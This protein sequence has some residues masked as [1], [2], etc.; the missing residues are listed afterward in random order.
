MFTNYLQYLLGTTWYNEGK[1][2]RQREGDRTVGISPPSASEVLRAVARPG[3]PGSAA[4][5][6]F[7]TARQSRKHKGPTGAGLDFEKFLR[8]FSLCCKLDFLK[9]EL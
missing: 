4:A 8:S 5:P 1:G 2:T 9:A 7:S 3:N 6:G